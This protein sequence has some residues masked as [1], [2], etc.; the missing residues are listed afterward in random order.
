VKRHGKCQLHDD[1]R[2]NGHQEQ[3]HSEQN[4]VQRGNDDEFKHGTLPPKIG[5]QIR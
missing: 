3:Q 5:L 4:A 2:Q 1:R